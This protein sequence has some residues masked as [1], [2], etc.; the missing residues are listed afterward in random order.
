LRAFEP[1]LLL[2]RHLVILNKIDLLPLYFPVTKIIA[3][4]NKRGWPCLALSALTGESVSI[5]KDLLW[6]EIEALSHAAAD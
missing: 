1:D 5:L 4:F 2:K 3:D 6:S